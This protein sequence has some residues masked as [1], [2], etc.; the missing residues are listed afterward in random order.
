MPGRR[1]MTCADPRALDDGDVLR[2]LALLALGPDARL[3][4]RGDRGDGIAPILRRLRTGGACAE[5]DD[6]ALLDDVA[7]G[8]G[9]GDAETE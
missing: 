2:E 5:L 4:R 1:C 8:W 6:D 7:R 9:A 3:S